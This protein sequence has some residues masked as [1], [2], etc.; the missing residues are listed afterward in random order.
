MSLGQRGQ[1][2]RL[3]MRGKHKSVYGLAQGLGRGALR[4]ENCPIAW[5]LFFSKPLSFLSK[6]GLGGFMASLAGA[7][8]QAV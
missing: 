3:E 8:L 1:A 7:N 6:P 2:S 4:C 5:S